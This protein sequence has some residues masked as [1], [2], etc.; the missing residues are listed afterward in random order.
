MTGWTKD[1][2]LHKEVVEAQGDLMRTFWKKCSVELAPQV[3]E[4][5]GVK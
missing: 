1:G 4:G 5:Y 3:K 2:M